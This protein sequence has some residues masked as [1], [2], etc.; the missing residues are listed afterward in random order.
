L[1]AFFIILLLVRI[2][3]AGG[4]PE[5]YADFLPAKKPIL[6]VQPIPDSLTAGGSLTPQSVYDYRFDRAS[7]CWV[8][9]VDTMPPLAIPP[10]AGFSDIM[11]PTKDSAR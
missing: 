1:S 8:P 2:L 9:W 11:V 6:T 10:G 3:A 7:C 4:A 5:G